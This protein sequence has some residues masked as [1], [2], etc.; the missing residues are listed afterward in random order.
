MR[1]TAAGLIVLAGLA[2]AA[3][4]AQAAELLLLERP[5]CVWCAR[6]ESEIGEVYARTA[7]GRRAPLRRVDITAGWPADLAAIRPDRFTPTFVLVDEGEEVARLHGYAG[8]EF[9]WF[10][11]D[12]MLDKLPERAAREEG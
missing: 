2:L 10:L 8:D 1:R 9:F 4:S 12:E 6:W 5:G 3:A 11:L 7:E